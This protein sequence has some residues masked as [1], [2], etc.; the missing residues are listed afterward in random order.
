LTGIC[1]S[2]SAFSRGLLAHSST[3]PSVLP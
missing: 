3:S 2:L 1:F